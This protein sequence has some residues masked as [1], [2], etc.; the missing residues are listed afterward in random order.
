MLHRLTLCITLSLCICMLHSA[1]MEEADALYDQAMEAMQ[2]MNEESAKSVE[3]AVHLHH[4]NAIYKEHEKWDK[5]REVNS[6]IFY[7]KKKMNV[8]E[9]DEYVAKLDRDQAE[10]VRRTFKLLESEVASA[11]TEED[12]TLSFREAE[13][14]AA[15]QPTEH[16]KIHMRFLEISERAIDSNPNL[17]IQAS[18]K[19]SEALQQWVASIKTVKK[20]ASPF[21]KPQRKKSLFGGDAGFPIPDRKTEKAVLSRLQ[22]QFNSSLKK[23]TS[24]R[25]PKDLLKLAR[26]SLDQPEYAYVCAMQ[27]ADLAMSKEVNDVSLMMTCFT[28]LEKHFGSADLDGIRKDLIT[29]Q[30][31]GLSKAVLTLFENQEDPEANKEV[32]LS[33]CFIGNNWKEGL[34]LLLNSKDPELGRIIAMEQA[35]PMKGNEQKQLADAW[36]ELSE[37][38]DYKDY[39]AEILGHACKWYTKAKAKVAGISKD[40]I[41]TRLLAAASKLPVQGLEGVPA[42]KGKSSILNKSTW[43]KLAAPIVEIDAGKGKQFSGVTLMKGQAIR[44]FPNTFDTWTVGAG[45]NASYQGLNN[46]FMSSSGSNGAQKYGSLQ[47]QVG[48]GPITSPDKPI[49]G[50]GK[51]YIFCYRGGFFSSSGSGSIRCKLARI[52]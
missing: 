43:S 12:S 33:Y 44:V 23:T 25:L 27:A 49:I 52:Q 10:G 30:R 19:S 29:S 1:T 9:L 14:F 22:K 36:F 42:A 2:A 28:F 7:C 50:E 48:D 4:A 26:E 13:S 37:N 17:A 8:N 38:R 15:S 39:A 3:A 51:V 6:Y 5:V 40:Q 45:G 20:T 35:K 47:V 21:T 32:G 18:R 24:N 16:L 41:E 31:T 11:M 46:Y 34:Q